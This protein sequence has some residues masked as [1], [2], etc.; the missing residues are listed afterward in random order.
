[1]KSDFLIKIRGDLLT[2][3]VVMFLLSG[4]IMM[5]CY[6]SA[7]A[8]W[9]LYIGVV[10]AG[11]IVVILGYLYEDYRR[12]PLRLCDPQKLKVAFKLVPGA[13]Q[14][15]EQRGLITKADIESFC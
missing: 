6:S 3:I 13:K 15:F 9:E 5:V 8:L 4:V 14:R 12:R 2:R 10:F 11:G 7:P 1:M